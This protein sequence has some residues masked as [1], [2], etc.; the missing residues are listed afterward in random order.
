[1]EYKCDKCDKKFE[2]GSGLRMHMMHAHKVVDKQENNSNIE[3]IHPDKD[4]IPVETAPVETAS[5]ADTPAVATKIQGAKS[6][7]RPDWNDNSWAPQH[8]LHVELKDSRLAHRWVRDDANSK[9]ASRLSEG[10]EFVR[11]KDVSKFNGLKL[12]MGSQ[13]DTILR[14]KELVCMMIPKTKVEARRAFLNRNTT[15]NQQK[16][17]ESL[18]NEF[19]GNVGK[20]KASVVEMREVEDMKPYKPDPSML[21]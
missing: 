19:R 12:E 14:V 7:E 21:S 4:A 5:Q 17:V 20:T 11:N 3:N 8:M 6:W 13:M 16:L 15:T 18:Q 1:M 2:K 10:W 9:V